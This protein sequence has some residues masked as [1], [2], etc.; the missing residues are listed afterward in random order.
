MCITRLLRTS[1]PYSPNQTNVLCYGYRL[2]ATGVSHI[3]AGPLE[4]Y[5]F[6][7]WSTHYTRAEWTELLALVGEEAVAEL[8]CTRR[9]FIGNSRGTFVQVC[10][11]PLN[12]FSAADNNSSCRRTKEEQLRWEIKRTRM[13]YG[14]P[15]ALRLRL[16][17]QELAIK[18]FYG[19]SPPSK[20]QQK[21]AKFKQCVALAAE[22]LKRIRKVQHRQLL[23]YHCAS[24]GV[25][26]TDV[27]PGKSIRYD[28]V[29][30]YLNAV[31]KRVLPKRMGLG[32]RAALKKLLIRLIELRRLESLSAAEVAPYL[33]L[34]E[35][36]WFYEAGK[37]R[38]KQEHDFTLHALLGFT[39]WIL[40]DFFLPLLRNSFYIT[41]TASTRNRLLY[42]HHEDWQAM[43]A[44][45]KADLIA[46][47]FEQ[48]EPGTPAA[49][50]RL[51]PKTEGAFRPIINPNCRLVVDG[52]ELVNTNGRLR[53][54][55]DVLNSHRVPSL[56]GNSVLGYSDV[57]AKLEA[58]AR[59]R[60]ASKEL[61]FVKADINS[62]F[63]SI[64]HRK[65]LEVMRQTIGKT[66][67]VIRTFD[68]WSVDLVSYEWRR[69]IWRNALPAGRLQSVDE[70]HAKLA[71][72]FPH[73]IVVD[74]AVTK[75]V[76]YDRIMLALQSHI[77][78][79][80]VRI[81][82]KNYRQLRG[83]PQG[84]MLS[85][86]LCAL[87]YAH[88]DRMHLSCF[89]VPG[90]LVMRYTD[91]F[92]LVTDRRE[93]ATEFMA[94]VSEGFE[95]YGVTFKTSKALTNVDNSFG[96]PVVSEER[97]MFPW[98]GLLI[99]MNNL[100][101]FADYARLYGIHLADSLTIDRTNIISKLR[102]QMGRFVRP[103]L[104]RIFRKQLVNL[105]DALIVVVAKSVAYWKQLCKYGARIKWRAVEELIRGGFAEWLT[106]RTSLERKV[107]NKMIEDAIDAVLRGKNQAGML[108]VARIRY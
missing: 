71:H 7:P 37:F 45:Y 93:I 101:V 25:F 64:P 91:D 46:N 50:L 72:R 66:S 24:G 78:A 105:K 48:G 74:R 84:S 98:I 36:C 2:A 8:L 40:K 61:H 75:T 56:M 82:G 99:D 27:D 6:N 87:F 23:D 77:A 3:E 19:C 107:A 9:V 41:E 62:C 70:L 20:S 1:S 90:T 31:L 100:S 49:P 97:A 60:N 65:L 10:G 13:L 108:D 69:R 15:R 21:T 52:S 86:L 58:Y 35:L 68:I 16:G 39:K 30:R 57:H 92:L 4:A 55:F 79:N 103:K 81:D 33:K 89:D 51:L 26:G 5:H 59:L 80:H 88:L 38:S 44:K 54:V 47:M 42:Y 63:D 104:H 102:L 34:T 67:Y 76:P 29:K 22:L 12:L 43:T 94:K 14:S 11:K 53:D 106:R 95:E 28:Q 18:A 73:S 96:V 32:Y 83:I 85:S 17:P